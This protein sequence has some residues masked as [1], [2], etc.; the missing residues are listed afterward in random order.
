MPFGISSA[1]EIWQCSME[2]ELGDIEGAEIIVDDL[3]V[4]ERN[5]EEH[6]KRLE[7]VLERALKSGLKLNRKKCKFSVNRITY[8]GHIFSSNGL[9]SNPE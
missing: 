1:S 6:D 3:V 5:D 2:E 9:E 8:V 4:W 7:Q